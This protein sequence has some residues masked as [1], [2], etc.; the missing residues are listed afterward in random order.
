MKTMLGWFLA[1]VMATSANLV[2]AEGGDSFVGAHYSASNLDV[3][4]PGVGSGDEDFAGFGFAGIWQVSPTAVVRG[5]FDASEGDDVDLTLDI[6]RL[7]VAVAGRLG[8]TIG[9]A[10][11]DYT[12]LKLSVEGDSDSENGVTPMVGLMSDQEAVTFLADAGYVIMDDVDGPYVNGE[13][14]FTGF[15]PLG[16]FVGYRYYFLEGEGGIDLDYSQ[17]RGGV[18]CQF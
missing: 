11:V 3:S 1:V 15:A 2:Q 6:L 9:Y 10:G 17:L 13:I 16:L 8:N 5:E 4:V 7:G 14:T 12:R 18:R